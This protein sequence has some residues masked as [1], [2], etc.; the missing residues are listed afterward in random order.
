MTT[1]NR[2]AH[3]RRGS[4]FAQLRKAS[5]TQSKFSLNRSLLP[6][7][8]DYYATQNITL[9]GRAEWRD[10]LCPF[11][12]DSSPSLRIHSVKGS[13]KCMVCEAKGGDIIAFHMAYTGLNFIDTCKALGAW[14]ESK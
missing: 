1:A 13:F 2:Y 4:Q 7:P 14:S 10:A 5:S 6:S 3:P 12:A 8:L 9:K 11:H